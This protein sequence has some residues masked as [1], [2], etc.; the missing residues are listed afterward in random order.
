MWYDDIRQDALPILEEIPS[1]G[2]MYYLQFESLFKGRRHQTTFWCT[3]NGGEK[4]VFDF[5]RDMHQNIAFRMAGM[6]SAE[7]FI[8]GYLFVKIFPP[9]YVIMPV[10]VAV[11]GFWLEPGCDL[12]EQ[13]YLSFITEQSGYRRHGR[14]F[15]FGMPA[16]WITNKRLNAEGHSRVFG[17][18]STWEQLF[19]PDYTDFPYTMGKMDRYI[20]GVKHS[21]LVP[22]NYWPFIK[23]YV[24]GRLVQHR[25]VNGRRPY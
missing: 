10:P 12:K 14:K 8:I 6:M 18:A 16:S 24:K 17:M 20:G 11:P 1:G 15:L 7:V 2:M 19:H 4:S 3:F 23:M 13:T 5:F 21:P 25:H 22:F 9:P